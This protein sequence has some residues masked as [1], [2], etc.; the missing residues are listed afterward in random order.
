MDAAPGVRTMNDRGRTYAA[1]LAAL[2]FGGCM[3][4]MDTE[5]DVPGQARSDTAAAK[6]AAAMIRLHTQCGDFDSNAHVAFAR[7][8]RAYEAAWPLV[9]DHVRACIEIAL[10]AGADP[11]LK[12][13][14]QLPEVSPV[15]RVL[16]RGDERLLQKFL[17][18]PDLDVSLYERTRTGQPATPL[19]WR[20]VVLGNL[21]VT[22]LYDRGASIRPFN[23]NQLREQALEQ[24]QPGM[25][26]STR[27]FQGYKVAT[28]RG[29]VLAYMLERE[30]GDTRE[31]ALLPEL[32][33][34]YSNV[35]LGPPATD[36]NVHQHLLV[37]TQLRASKLGPDP[38]KKQLVKLYDEGR[39]HVT[40]DEHD[41]PGL[42]SKLLVELTRLGW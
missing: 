1:I 22:K 30:D 14:S 37:F 15:G 35:S 36:E 23:W 8:M 20:A 33:K 24:W 19:L 9:V 10:D 17:A 2:L 3:A 27:W 34:K 25:D 21:T 41:L 7:A 16:D 28:Q 6:R 29:A 18:H 13:T 5:S 11:N 32:M 38:W 26:M 39:K 31:E 12:L 42:V 40:S 4:G